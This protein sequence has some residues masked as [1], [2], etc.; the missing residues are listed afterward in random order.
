MHCDGFLISSFDSEKQQIRCEFAWVNGNRLDPA[1]LPPVVYKP[2]AGMQS[3]VIR[4]GKPILFEDVSQR[5]KDPR[6]TFYDVHPDGEIVD[7]AKVEEPSSQC[8]IVAPIKVDEIVLGVVQVISEEPD[9]YTADSLRL[10]EGLVY[11]LAIAQQNAHLYERA[12]REIAE[13]KRVEQALRQAE[14]NLLKTLDAMPHIA[15]SLNADATVDYINRRLVEY[16]GGDDPSRLTGQSGWANLVH[17]EDEKRFHEEYRRCVRQGEIWDCEIRLL[18]YDGVYRW[19]LNRMVPIRGDDGAI[20]RWF[21]TAT[22]IHDLKMAEEKLV[23]LNE[24][25]EQR[26]ESRTLELREAIHEMEGFTYSVSHDLRGPLRAISATSSILLADAGPDLSEDMRDMLVRQANSAKRLGSL[27]DDL[28]RL[29]RVSRSDM[30]LSE[31]DLSGLAKELRE[32]LSGRYATSATIQ[33]EEGLAAQGDMQLIRLV[34]AN[35]L[36]NAIKFSPRGGTIYVGQSPGPAFFVRDEGVGFDSQYADKIWLPFER[37]V[38]ESEFP[39]TGIGLANVKRI[40]ERHGGRV[41]AESSPGDGATF[42]FTLRKEG[43][44]ER[45]ETET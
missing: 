41:W 30:V 45:H 6:A 15:W 18:R 21:G 27:I 8:A 28:L 44:E 7:I 5:A 33:I 22:D 31:I 3:Q 39:G 43:P 9:V 26:V 17:P 12:R 24:E 19:H 25:L 14:A 32:E 11:Q 40:V 16:G 2:D 23:E 10:L 29:S 35:L 20:I 4:T 37:L 34:L 13:R 38:G 1:L 42:Y 36:E